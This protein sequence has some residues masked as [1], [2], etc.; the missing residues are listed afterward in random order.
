VKQTLAMLLAGGVGSRLSVLVFARAK[1]A[2]PFGGIYRVIDFTLSNVMNS[3]LDT[4]GVLT[5]YKPLSLME[6]IGTGEA[7]DFVGRTRGVKIL[8]PRTGE[9]ASD[10][11][12]GTADAIRQNLD[13]ITTHNPEYVLVLSGDHIY[14]MDYSRMIAFHRD[15]NA[16]LTIAMMEVPV[17]ETRHFGIAETRPDGRIIGWQEKPARPMSTL[18]SMGI[19]LF[20]RALLIEMLRSN[21]GNDFGEDVIPEAIRKHHVFAYRFSGY[22]RDVGTLEA[23]WRTHMDLLDPESGMDLDTWRVRTNF[24]E[25]GRSGDRPPALI[26]PSATVHESVISPG[27]VIRGH[28]ERSILSPGV[29]V[30]RDVRLVDSVVMHDVRLR[31]GAQVDF[32]IIDKEVLIGENARIGVGSKDVAN[33]ASPDILNNGLVLIGKGAA[34]PAGT[35]IGR[36]TVVYPWT[37]PEQY[38]SQVIPPGSTI[39]AQS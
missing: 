28:V 19:Y 6:H 4:V 9:R 3:G 29:L 31:R 18:A 35:Q 10:W 36:N 26:T 1:P 30:D 23:Y 24:E 12:K 25:E 13:F 2:V 37:G 20:D 7:W 34:V 32:A 21:P 17:E 5:Q 33:Q 16:D 15:R 8:P 11:Y 27:C 22:W 39:Q 38:G 14:Y